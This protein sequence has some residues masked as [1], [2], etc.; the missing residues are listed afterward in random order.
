MLNG[1]PLVIV[2]VLVY[3]VAGF[4]A[5]RYLFAQERVVSLC[6]A[7][8]AG[9]LACIFAP[10]ACD[11][12]YDCAFEMQALMLVIFFFGGVFGTAI[13]LVLIDLFKTRRPGK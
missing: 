12:R 4:A 8:G 5:V 2:G 13:L 1:L 7:V 11:G 9:L 6:Y 3:L 10:K